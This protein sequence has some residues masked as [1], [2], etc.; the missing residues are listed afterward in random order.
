MENSVGCFKILISYP[1]ATEGLIIKDV[2]ATTSIHEYHSEFV[3]TNLRRHYQG[4]VTLI[5]NPGRVIRSTPH[6]GLLRPSQVMGSCRLNS[7]HN[8]LM[9]LL[10]PLA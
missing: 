6:N 10:V 2:D 9:E 3:S 1:H 7:V 8:P 5:V 4:Q